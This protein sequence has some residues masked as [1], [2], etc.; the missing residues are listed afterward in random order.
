L[1]LIAYLS[2]AFCAKMLQKSN[3]L[4]GLKTVAKV[5]LFGPVKSTG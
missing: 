5:L 3:I 2:P 4:L 1:W